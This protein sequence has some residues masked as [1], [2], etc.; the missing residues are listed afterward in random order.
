M[1]NL[2]AVDCVPGGTWEVKLTSNA[3]TITSTLGTVQKLT[4]DTFRIF[5]IPQS[6]GIYHQ[7]GLIN[8]VCQASLV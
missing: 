3:P 5:N 2:V 8:N 4:L 6:R 1:L 7:R